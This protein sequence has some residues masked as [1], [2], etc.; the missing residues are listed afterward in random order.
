MAHR[1]NISPLRPYS[2]YTLLIFF[3][4]LLSFTKVY[5]QTPLWGFG[6]G[7]TQADDGRVVRIAPNGNVIFGGSFSGTIDLDPS[8]GVFNLTSKGQTDIFLACYTAGGNFLWGFSIG[9]SAGDAIENISIDNN[10][11]IAIVGY[12]RGGFVDFDPS[13]SNAAYL[14]G[15]GPAN[16]QCDGFVAKYT[17]TGGY[18][19]AI[20]LGGSTEYDDAQSVV[21]DNEGNVYVGGNFHV[22]MDIDPSPTVTKALNS[23]Y[24]TGFLIKYNPAGVPV[25]GFTFG[26]GVAQY[27][28]DNTVWSIKT[29]NNGYLYL[30]GCFQGTNC[31]FDPDPL[32]STS[33][34]ADGLYDGY[35]AKY[36]TAGKFVWVREIKGSKI[37]Q[38]IDLA[39]S[40]AND[41]YLI[42]FTESPIMQIGGHTLTAPG[43]GKSADIYIASYSNSGQFRWTNL[44]GDERYDMGWGI[45]VLDNYV[46]CTG[47]FHDS[48]DLDPSIATSI[49]KSAGKME[50]F[51]AKYALNGNFE[52]AF[53][54]G[55]S[56]NDKGRKL[57]GDANGF[58]Y[59]AGQFSSSP[60]DL[61]P[62]QGNLL[63]NSAGDG[64]AYLTKYDLTAIQ[65]P[66]GGYLV[67]D[68][69]CEGDNAYLTFIATSGEGP[70]EIT[71]SDGTKE[72]VQFNVE[73]GKPFVLPTRPTGTTVYTMSQLKGSGLCSPVSTE[74]R[75]TTILVYPR[76]TADAGRDTFVC[77][78]VQVQLNGTGGD[79][80][81]WF[82]GAQLS[83]PNIYNPVVTVDSD[84]LYHFTIV[85]SYGCRDTDDVKVGIIPTQF[86][87]DP[88][89][90]LCLG[91]TLVLKASGGDEY[92]WS[93]DSLI[94][95]IHAATPY[96]WTQHDM[97][98]TVFIKEN[99]CGRSTTLP[100]HV[101][102]LPKPNIRIAMA[103][104]IDC[105]KKE[106]YLAAT[107]GVQY[108]WTPADGLSDPTSASTIAKPAVNTLYTVTGTDEN[109]CSNDTTAEIKVFEGAG[110]LFVPTAFTPN[111]DGLNDCIKVRM[112]GD[113]SNYTLNIMNRWGERVFHGQYIGD[114]WDGNYKGMPQPTDTY[115]YYYKATSS[116]C[117]D[118]EGKGDVHLLR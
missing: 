90:R 32:V 84:V 34:T 38:T 17:A 75:A 67:G 7:G 118:V 117:G 93:P 73:S 3:F 76:P 26:G 66:P 33:L 30:G 89:Q 83:D 99:T 46:Y 9:G 57:A 112:P 49:I 4:L 70:F 16:N 81:L 97:D 58:L 107:G 98:Y 40:P 116:S 103:R 20:A 105:G 60:I 91:D 51:V 64:D 6:A 35:V 101:K 55:G 113:V 96:T 37:E 77:P 21:M 92:L 45:T 78:G 104:D 15:K 69:V 68:T 94:S 50:G 22:I 72:F 82:P 48:I 27:G 28:I 11:N 8:G 59:L 80:P 25:W 71:Y 23:L 47:Y 1:T 85:N 18:Q 5:G 74:Q 115:F 106:G 41:I 87:L 53:P 13:A 56:D 39:L 110:R 42:G 109:G 114:C 63:L 19:W 36:D 65:S 12:F 24:G 44:A 10:N 86:A 31:D 54:V 62:T 79:S 111:N 14:H 43:T 29:D 88:Q 100:V 61:D 95:D 108:V 52:C 2:A 102:V